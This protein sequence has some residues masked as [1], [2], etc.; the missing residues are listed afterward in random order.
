MQVVMHTAWRV[1]GVGVNV[2]CDRYGMWLVEND[3]FLN[4]I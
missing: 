2:I 1:M 3:E 4:G